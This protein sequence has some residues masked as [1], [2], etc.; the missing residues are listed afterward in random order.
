MKTAIQPYT[1][2]SMPRI[3][4]GLKVSGAI[5][6]TGDIAVPGL[7]HA[8]LV[9]SPIARGAIR[10]ADTSGA[11]AVPGV[12]RVFTP[13]TMPKLPSK[14][15]QPDWDIMYGSSF[16]PMADMTIHYAGQPIGLILAET[17]EAAQHAALVVHLERARRDAHVAA[18][19]VQH[20]HAVAAG[21]R[22]LDQA[23][24]RI[25]ARIARQDRDLHAAGPASCAAPARGRGRV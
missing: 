16:V 1:G 25:Q 11:E 23:S 17:L 10:S 8:V 20:A 18:Q 24:G 22:G 15:E 14:P 4:A 3:E 21:A 13:E 12:V 19:R 7:L 5:A 9:P 2:R 6:Y